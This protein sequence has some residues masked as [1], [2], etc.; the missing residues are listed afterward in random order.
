M[1]PLITLE[2]ELQLQ[3]VSYTAAQCRA[4]ARIYYRWA[5][6]LFVKARI[7]DRVAGD[8]AAAKRLKP[9]PAAKQR[10]N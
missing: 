5:R 9:I 8:H 4:L 3:T 2:P 6:Q 1:K 10:W 7:L